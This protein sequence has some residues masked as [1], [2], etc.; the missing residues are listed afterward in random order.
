MLTDAVRAPVAAGVKVTL[1]VQLPPAGGTLTLVLQAVLVDA[2]AKSPLFV[3]VILMLVKFSAAL[4][5]F[6]SVTV[7]AVLVVPMLWLLNVRLV[8]TKDAVGVPPAPVKGTVC[9][10]PVALSVMLTDPVR[11]P[12]AVGVNVTMMVQVPC[13]GTLSLLAKHVLVGAGASAKSPALVPVRLTLVML[14]AEVPVF[15][16]VTVCWGLVVPIC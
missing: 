13:G 12:A 4:P 6:V 16:S 8:G 2:S 11:V 1:T 10:L 3:P 7:W 5:V 9:G 15:V 14:R